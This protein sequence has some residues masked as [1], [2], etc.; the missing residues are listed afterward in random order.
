MTAS[1]ACGACGNV[2]PPYQLGRG[3]LG[4]VQALEVLERAG[5]EAL[6]L[7]PHRRLG[8]W[9]ARVVQLLPAEGRTLGEQW[10]PPEISGIADDWARLGALHGAL[11]G[12]R[13]ESLGHARQLAITIPSL[14]TAYLAGY[15]STFWPAWQIRTGGG[16]LTAKMSI[17]NRGRTGRVQETA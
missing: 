15:Y 11:D 9:T 10:R 7:D 17:D 16:D 2:R 14:L 6:K 4:I 5:V 1:K 3:Q 8:E 12:W 13:G